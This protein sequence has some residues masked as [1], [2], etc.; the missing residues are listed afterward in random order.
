LLIQF[1]IDSEFN[2]ESDM[3]VFNR[4]RI[5]WMEVTVNGKAV[6]KS[7]Q[8]EDEEVAR[9]KERVWKLEA[10]GRDNPARQSAAQGRTWQEACE[11][12]LTDHADKRSAKD[13]QR[14]G[15]WWNEN[16]KGRLLSQLDRH[17]INTI[18]ERRARDASPSTANRYRAF[19]TAVINAAVEDYDWMDTPLKIKRFREPKGIVRFLTIEQ[20]DR[21][22][23][24]LPQHQR[25]MAEFALATGARQAAVKKLKWTAVNLERGMAWIVP[26]DSKNGEPV[27]MPLNETAKEVLRR[28]QGKHR[29]YVFTYEGNPIANV[30]TQAWVKALKRAG[31]EGYRWHDFRHTWASHHAMNGTPL[32][33]LQAM[34]G[35]SDPKMVKRYAHLSPESLQ[36]Y[37]GNAAR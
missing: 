9:L 13:D 31:L 16:L 14:Y 35:W 21:L 36:Q 28:C 2:E 19:F 15:A 3:S 12:W 1:G 34:G 24:E 27:P 33:A 32:Q 7:C 29:D 18:L 8:T 4:G 5:W 22:L 23:A 26:E 20:I 10:Q 25:D 30:N 37:A 17:E 11:R 6:R